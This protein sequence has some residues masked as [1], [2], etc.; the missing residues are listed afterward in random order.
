MSALSLSPG[1]APVAMLA[2]LPPVERAAIRC[3]RGWG[4]SPRPAR[5]G[6]EPEAREEALDMVMDL[7]L[8]QG[9]RPLAR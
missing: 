2:D 6:G 9:R 5:L 8:T 1:A 7:V 4:A 3:P